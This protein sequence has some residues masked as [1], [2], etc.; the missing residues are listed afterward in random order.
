MKF[1][2]I[3][4]ELRKSNNITQVELAKMLNLTQSSVSEWENEISRPEY[5][6]LIKLADIFDVSLDELM[7][8]K[9]Y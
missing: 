1:A 4:K 7:G 2:I 5:E 9:D 8:R 3:L 6:N